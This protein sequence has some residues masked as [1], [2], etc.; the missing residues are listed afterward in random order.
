MNSA[1]GAAGGAFLIEQEL[2]LGAQPREKRA[3]ASRQPHV[4]GQRGAEGQVIAERA[5]LVSCRRTASK[6]LRVVR[7]RPVEARPLRQ[8]R[9]AVL[10]RRL[11]PLED[12]AMTSLGV[13]AQ[14]EQERR[15]AARFA[16][17]RAPPVTASD[18]EPSRTG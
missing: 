4:L 8:A 6:R 11:R 1:G 3:L 15:R 17:R 9:V 18:Q 2:G 12:G 16:L 14:L 13:V 7:R 10:D 5:D